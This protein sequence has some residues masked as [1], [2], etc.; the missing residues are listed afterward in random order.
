MCYTFR[1][2]IESLPELHSQFPDIDGFWNFDNLPQTES[3]IQ[4]MLPSEGPWKAEQVEALTQLAHAQVLQNKMPEAKATLIQAQQLIALLEPAER[5]R[6]EIRWLL[7]QG[8]VF[9]LSMTPSKAIEC[10]GQAWTLANKNNLTFFAIESA[11]MLAITQP[12]KSRQQW[13][14]MAL[15]LA[16]KATSEQC[17]LWLAQ[18]YLMQGWH[19]FDVHRFDKALEFFEK[20]VARPRFPGDNQKVV[21]SKWSAARA[22]RALGRFDEAMAIQNSLL[23]ELTEKG[24]ENGHVYLEIG[25][26]MQAQ[27]KH[28]EAKAFFEKAYKLLSADQW[29]SDNRNFELSRIQ[30]ISKKR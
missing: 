21:V 10:F 6:P 4:M 15:D 11:L 2:R 8:R 24:Q 27:Q 22:I 18:L 30:Y 25:E 14:E 26:C 3:R 17:K 13:L 7:E 19:Y 9:C 28:E 1:M 23:N 12:L 16:E 29:Y 5:I 20:S